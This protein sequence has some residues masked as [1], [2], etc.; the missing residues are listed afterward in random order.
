MITELKK[1]LSMFIKSRNSLVK[2]N[3]YSSLAIYFI[4]LF[5]ID[6]SGA[7]DLYGQSIVRRCM[8]MYRRTDPLS[9]EKK[10]N[11]FCIK[12]KK[13]LN[14]SDINRLKSIKLPTSTDFSLVSRKNTTTHQCC[15]KYSPHERQIMED[16][17]E[18]LRTKY[19]GK[20][21]KK[22]Y[23]LKSNTASIYRYHGNKS[24]HL[25]HLDPQNI[26][27]I[28]N[29]IL[30]IGKKGNISPLQ[31]K[32]INNRAYSI[33]FNEGDGALFNGGTTV[34]QVP[35]NDDPESERT[36]LSVAFTSSK[37][38]ADNEDF[39]KNL[40]TY[41]EGGNN[42]RNVVKIFLYIVLINHSLTFISGINLISYKNL[43]LLFGILLLLAKYIPKHFD[44]G[45]GT[46]RASSIY[47]NLVLLCFFVIT[48][49]SF[50]GAIVFFSYFLI[51]DIIFS[52]KWV[53]YD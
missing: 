21:G 45:I 48:T 15:D 47:H 18:K 33:H 27:E 43:F 17:M 36:V 12:Y 25:W 8:N 7:L 35:P 51:S 50:K 4:I 32:D 10:I 46:G 53:G 14:N 9:Y 52:R 20:I 39:G 13:I 1:Y 38:I 44:I 19:E 26:P 37:E 29:V 22:L 31:C 11:P 23:Y 5:L 16:I 49:M 28:Y 30:C 3:K 6:Y 42:Y 40:C 24:K 41:T 34:H 2:D